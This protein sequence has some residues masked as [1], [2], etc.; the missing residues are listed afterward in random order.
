ML[1]LRRPLLLLAACAAANF[2][3]AD[4]ALRDGD[5]VV[6]LGDS[7]TAARGY[8]KIVEQYTLMRYPERKVRFINAGKGG[9]TASGSLERL[10][11]DVFSKGATVVT[12]AFGVNDILWG[13]KAD[14][15]HKQLY[16]DGI[17][18]I[19]ERCQARQVRPFICS[20]AI[21]AGD[22][23]KAERGF[24]QKMADEGLALA[25]SLGAETI[26]LQRGMREVQRRIVAANAKESDPKKHIR[27]HLDDSVHLNDLGQLAMAYAM[28]KGLGAP[29]DVSSATVNA[30]TGELLSAKGCRL[31]A[32]EK[33]SDGLDFVRLDEGLPLNLG[34][35]SGLNY[36]WVSIPE[37]LNRYL[38]TVSHL[39]AG[40]YELRAEGRLLGK[41]SA[42]RLAR[43][44]NLAS[45]SPNPWHPGGPWEAQSWTVK[46]LVDARDK[47][48]MSGV[49]RSGSL[50]NH[51]Q[52]VE[53]VRRTKDLDD[54]LVALQR[55]T[56]KPYAHHFEIRKAHAPA[57]AQGPADGGVTIK[58][59]LEY[60]QANG[61][62][63]LL[64]AY[65]PPDSFA[66]PQ[67]AVMLVHGGGW[68]GGDRATRYLPQWSKALA[69]QGFAAFS[70]DYRLVHRPENGKP[71]QN[72][73]PA[74]LDDC[75]RA[76]RWL[77]CHAQ[78]FGIRPGRIAGLGESAGGHLVALLGTTD[79]RDNT[80]P[81]LARYSSRLNAVVDLYGP[82]DLTQ[83]LTDLLF[84]GIT[85]R[86]LVDNFVGPDPAR[87]RE[88]SPRWH[89]DGQTPPFLIM[90]G[91]KDAL[92]PVEQ[93]RNFYAAL[94]KAGRTSTYIE[95]PEE[96]H[97]F[98]AETNRGRM[99]AETLS[100]LRQTFQDNPTH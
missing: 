94:Q 17:R 29:A 13:M 59:N 32:I 83:P 74:A 64:D 41:V 21:M 61:Q 26:D 16:L 12:V 20:P 82:A 98:G 44:L 39:P 47:L 27:L 24:L 89:I 54:Q 25:K 43:G 92:V 46:E 49:L 45:T 7:I 55:L 37:G 62:K 85:P 52:R 70:I 90:H 28:L 51:P 3:H 93:S 18:A 40:E 96:N 77:R 81:E 34:A 86:Q 73:Y 87:R 91:A 76:V 31:S 35:F 99:M 11:R 63:L 30:A 57:T 84:F 69:E 15:E 56:A 8:T 50:T 65:L 66:R 22:P 2:A 95:F 36:R 100:F 78:Q 19:V 79:T 71:A 60:G 58:K 6:F 67:P 38:L 48:W 72:Q 97:G 5:T 42:A 14:A 33:H 68:E 23:D 88:A 53:L 9:D 10:D 1:I 80:D 4:F 75:Q